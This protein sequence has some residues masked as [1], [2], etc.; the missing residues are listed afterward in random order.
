MSAA[1]RKALIALALTP[2]L[3][4]LFFG[5][6]LAAFAVP[7]EPIIRSLTERP[8]VLASRRADNGRV[9]DADTE[10]IGL[11]I[12]LDLADAPAPLLKRTINA[13]SLY[14]C[15][16]LF[17]LFDGSKT[18][19][20]RD[21][22]RY[23]HG[24]LV[25][26]R[27]VLAVMPYN[28]LRGYLFTL[29][30]GLFVWLVWR[31]GE[32]LGPRTA[33]AVA[34]PFIVINAMGLW[35]V[36]T[37]ATTWLLAIGAGL[38]LSRRR[39]DETPLLVFFI[40]G[41]LTAFLDFF[42]APAFVFCFAALVW[43]LYEKRARREP[44]WT[45]FIL[46]GAFW[47]AGWAGFI[48]LKIVI[49]AAALDADVWRNFVDAALFRVRGESE[50]VD[51]F[52]PGAALYANIAAM[53]SFWA[54]VAIIAFMILPFATKPRRSR[55][56]LLARDRSVLLGIAAAPLL[57]MEVFSNHTQIHA[58]FTQIN[59]APAFI[60]AALVLAGSVPMPILGAD[61]PIPGSTQGQA[62]RRTRGR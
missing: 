34:A 33:L 32:D 55:W 57:W 27:P 44:A 28:D 59:Y 41:A 2:F 43:A 35:V 8:D 31:I 25:I 54:P 40:L 9:I 51:S 12:G 52:I 11:S 5:A 62:A 61:A 49:A 17:H 10:C 4:A 48:L 21:Y 26:A 60:L 13:Q 36:A 29:S 56:A 3:S 47:A 50:Y 6:I 7:N 58:A 19:K 30:A 42:T 14:G 46:M 24:Y 39:A 23:W 20:V 38:V 16:P 22:F 15:E 53:K 37:K 18:E 1:A 45:A